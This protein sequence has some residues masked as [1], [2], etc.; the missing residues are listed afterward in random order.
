MKRI[1][2]VLAPDCE[3][4]EG[5]EVAV[6]EISETLSIHIQHLASAGKLLGVSDIRE[7]NYY[8][9]FFMRDHENE[10]EDGPIIPRSPADEDEE[11]ACRV[12][13][14]TLVVTP[15]EFYWSGYIKHTDIR[16]ETKDIPLAELGTTSEPMPSALETLK[17][18]EASI[19]TGSINNPAIQQ[20]ALKDIRR[21]LLRPQKAHLALVLDGHEVVQGVATD[22][23]DLFEG[24]NVMVIDYC[25]EGLM[26]G[27]VL[28][29]SDGHG[30]PEPAKVLAWK[31]PM[32]NPTMGYDLPGLWK[33]LNE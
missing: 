6:V 21:A 26:P 27:K 20:V 4:V 33:A 25:H 1:L 13:G 31:G 12:E 30:E 2:E 10:T 17:K 14:M 8:P 24:V 5:P 19:C 29:V 15:S 22:A 9:E 16:V 3:Y 32:E 18:V 28:P 23:P 11:R 7:Y